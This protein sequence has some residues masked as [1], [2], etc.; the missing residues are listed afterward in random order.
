VAKPLRTLSVDLTVPKREMTPEQQAE[1]NRRH[2]LWEPFLEENSRKAEEA[3]RLTA[4]D[5]NLI[6]R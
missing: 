1:F 5:W 6:V 3:E 2:A 4:E